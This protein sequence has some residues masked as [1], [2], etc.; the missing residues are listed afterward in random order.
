MSKALSFLGPRLVFC[1][2]VV[3][4]PKPKPLPC[5]TDDDLSYLGRGVMKMSARQQ[6]RRV[7]VPLRDEE[8]YKRLLLI[9]YA[10]PNDWGVLNSLPREQV[11]FITEMLVIAYYASFSDIGSNNSS[12]VSY[13]QNRVPVSGIN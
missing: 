1:S 2:T 8:L 9:L 4:V 13:Y 7:V 6:I 3:Y 5:F 11:D 12:E 10:A